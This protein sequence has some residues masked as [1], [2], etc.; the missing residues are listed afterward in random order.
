MMEKND[1]KSGTIVVLYNPTSREIENLKDNINRTDLAIIIDNSSDNHYSIIKSHL[2]EGCQWIYRS[3]SENIGLCK[4][5]NVGI[6]ILY[7][8]GCSWA[9]ILDADSVVNK[10]I[11]SVYKSFLEIND[12]K[13][14]AIL[15]PI[16]NFGRSK[17]KT[18]DGELEV[19]R[20]MTSGWFINIEI[21]MKEG[22]FYEPLFVDGL[23]H[24]YCYRVKRDGYRI[25]QCG[26]AM[27]QH[28]PGHEYQ[29]KILGKS[30]KM[31]KDSPLRYYMG[32]RGEW[33][34]LLKNKSLYDGAFYFYRLVKVILFFH[35]KK[36]YIC[37]MHK[38]RNEGI[39]LFINERRSKG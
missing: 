26:R 10:N 4:A 16:H 24:D 8:N 1:F 7:Q 30:F 36:E 34:N 17:K 9:L 3:Y 22:K 28:N 18:Y 23:D 37:E 12:C 20:S 27:I 25:I 11:V 15:V 35:N 14:I 32:A 39:N 6:D 21:F 2:P 29:V 13:T 33:W 19:K 31:G 38:G 5:L